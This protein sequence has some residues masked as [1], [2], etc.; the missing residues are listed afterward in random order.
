M[1]SK[2][3]PAP[4][5][6]PVQDA[7]LSVEIIIRFEVEVLPFITRLPASLYR[8][9]PTGLSAG[10]SP[11]PAFPFGAHAGAGAV[12]TLSLLLSD[13]RRPRYVGALQTILT[14]FCFA[15]RSVMPV[16]A[17]ELLAISP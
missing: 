6:V 17:N 8:E 10:S 11:S 14:E 13:S 12:A 15:P 7:P 3:G 5:N 16:E 1:N 2:Y 9:T 4:F